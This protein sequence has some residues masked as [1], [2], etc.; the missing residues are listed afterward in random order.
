[1]SGLNL[2]PKAVLGGLD[3]V[4]PFSS[5]TK[6]SGVLRRG[7]I[8]R[9]QRNNRRVPCKYTI[10]PLY[11]PNSNR[12]ST[13]SLA[14]A[15]A[16]QL[17]Q[18]SK[19]LDTLSG[20]LPDCALHSPWPAPLPKGSRGSIWPLDDRQHELLWAQ[21]GSDIFVQLAS[22]H[23]MHIE[24]CSIQTNRRVAYREHSPCPHKPTPFHSI[25]FLHQSWYQCIPT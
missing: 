8:G 2:L 1:M 25:A 11:L 20:E 14:A 12:W 6:G 3:V 21:K 7:L 23:P 4:G 5:T 22:I 10:K 19:W 15:T 13:K 18:G 17:L 16:P 9:K 24:S